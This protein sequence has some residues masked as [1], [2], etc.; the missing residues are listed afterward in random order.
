MIEPAAPRPWRRLG[1]VAGGGD[2]PVLLSQAEPEAFILKLRGFCDGAFGD[3]EQSEVGI[4]EFGKAFKALREANCDAVCFSGYVKRPNFSALKPDARGAL[5]L[6]KAVAAARKGDDGLLQALLDEFEKNGF[7]AVGADEV[8][9]GLKPEAGVLG[10]VQPDETGRADAQKAIHIAREIGALD[11]GQGAVV[12]EGL[13][14]AVEAQ[15]GTNA[16]LERVAG[17]PDDVR[18]DA[19]N[20]R[21]VLGKAPKPIQDRRIDL[22]TFGPETVRRAAAAGLSG[23]AMEAGAALILDREALVE[24]ADA[25]GV[26]LL[27]LEATTS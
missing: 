8:L 12:A 27:S 16:M 11:I 22:P 9:D 21:G 1:L 4:A 5:F 13:V 14:L 17:L 18:G 24:A 6:P 7:R 2:L 23:L 26:F 20:R 10:S 3:R 19:E 25:A 15:E